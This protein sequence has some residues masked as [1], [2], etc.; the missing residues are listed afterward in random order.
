MDSAGEPGN[1]FVAVLPYVGS[2]IGGNG[3]DVF[4][5]T[6]DECPGVKGGA[7]PDGRVYAS[8]T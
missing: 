1:G 5:V 7:H 4:I 3:R 2:G 6:V 8:S